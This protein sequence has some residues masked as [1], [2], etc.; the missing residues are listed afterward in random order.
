MVW[1][2]STLLISYPLPSLF[3]C[4]R[5]RGTYNQQTCPP[6]YAAWLPPSVATTS[7]VTHTHPVEAAV[8]QSSGT[9]T[10]PGL[11]RDAIHR[12][13]CVA[14]MA[15]AWALRGY[16]HA[17]LRNEGYHHRTR[18]VGAGLDVGR[19]PLA[20]SHSGQH[21]QLR[22]V[23]SI[24]GTRGSGVVRFAVLPHETRQRSKNDRTAS[25]HSSWHCECQ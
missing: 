20:P 8:A 7:V 23:L 3:R 6:A 17:W 10:R 21:S 22:S 9:E 18:M 24:R 1:Y 2:C 19:A 5:N 13:R 25:G 14:L 12:P 16:H 4:R 11:S 15:A